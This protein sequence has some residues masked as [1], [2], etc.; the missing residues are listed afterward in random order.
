M[1]VKNRSVTNIDMSDE[2]IEIAKRKL[3]H[4]IGELLISVISDILQ[5]PT[6][7]QAKTLANWSMAY[8]GLEIMSLDPTLREFQSTRLAQRTFILDTDYILD[9]IVKECPSSTV[10]IA[11][12]KALREIGCRIMLPKSCLSECVAHALISTRTYNHFGPRLF[13]LSRELVDAQVGNVFVKGYYFGR[14]NGEIENTTSYEEYLSNYLEKTDSMSFFIEVVKDI[15]PQGIEICDPSTL[16]ET[17]ITKDLVSKLS[18]ALVQVN[19]KSRKSEYRSLENVERLAQ[20][21]AE[22]FI[23]TQA[24]SRQFQQAGQTLGTSCCYLVTASGKYRRGA[25]ILNL[26]DDVTTRPA[27]LLGILHLVGHVNMSPSQY[28]SLFENPMLIYAVGQSWIDIEAL[29]ESGI[30][31]KN[32]SIAC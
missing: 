20:L 29:L 7:E 13:A 1:G 28:I 8:L 26:E 32:K 6:E 4:E 16:L 9:C 15:L 5:K 11:L 25:K 10:N 2:L 19:A 17:K 18:T 30:T 27:T 24:L 21:D 12:L 23:T 14:L 3:N 22:L 31:L